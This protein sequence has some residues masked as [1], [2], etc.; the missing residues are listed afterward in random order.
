MA[1]D[2]ETKT[3]LLA[4]RTL[5]FCIDHLIITCVGVIF[6]FIFLEQLNNA[7]GIELLFYVSVVLA[8]MTMP[9]FAKDLL[10]GKS[11]GKRVMGLQVRSSEN[12]NEV[13]SKWQLVV[14]N[15]TMFIWPIEFLVL[16]LN[17][18]GRRLGDMFSNTVMVIEEQNS[19][20]SKI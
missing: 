18:E 14:R 4:R 13:P 2:R 5:A 15:I 6:I 9:Y 1:L 3:S 19:S 10:K 16:V 20:N 11:I 8:L 7:Y 12:N 17:K